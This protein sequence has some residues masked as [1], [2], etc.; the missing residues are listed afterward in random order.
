MRTS[1]VVLVALCAV[2]LTASVA[3]AEFRHRN[4]PADWTPTPLQQ[5]AAADDGVFAWSLVG[6]IFR[7]LFYFN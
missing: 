5:F 1:V 6:V 3:R 4:M 7:H 2:V